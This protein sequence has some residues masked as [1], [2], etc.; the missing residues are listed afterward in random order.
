MHSPDVS[1]LV[2]LATKGAV[3]AFDRA[4]GRRIWE[5]RLANWNGG[6][7]SLLA[8]HARVFAH[9]KGK[10]YCLD[11]PTGRILWED[12]LSGLGYDLA[13]LAFPGGAMS[14]DPSGAAEA[15]RLAAAASAHASSH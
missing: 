4:S 15:R 7:V 10:L 8:D 1:D 14:S 11:L 9:A 12:G 3:L 2:L 5:T 6:Y 13:S